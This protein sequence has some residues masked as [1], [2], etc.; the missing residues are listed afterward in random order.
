MSLLPFIL[1]DKREHV[2]DKENT[3][4]H[5]HHPPFH[6]AKCI[7]PLSADV[8]V[9]PSVAVA[10]Q[11][12]LSLTIS[13][14]TDFVRIGYWVRVQDFRVASVKLCDMCSCPL[15]KKRTD[16]GRGIGVT[17]YWVGGASIL[18]YHVSHVSLKLPGKNLGMAAISTVLN[19]PSLLKSRILKSFLP[20]S[21]FFDFLALWNMEAVDYFG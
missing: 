1:W 19:V 7:K 6:Y 17:T 13:A 12:F 8:I 4:Q 5:C 9:N 16:S 18:G 3:K 11:W 2:N 21:S 10:T 15:W 20:T 14:P